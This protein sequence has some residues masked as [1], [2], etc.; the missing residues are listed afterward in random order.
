[1][2]PGHLDIPS[3][4]LALA[5]ALPLSTASPL[6]AQTTD[7][8]APPAAPLTIQIVPTAARGTDRPAL[9][10]HEPRDHFHVVLTNVSK[11]TIR[12]W[13]EWCS[14]G[15]YNLSFEA[16]N[17]GG[18]PKVISKRIPGWDDN[19][20]DWIALPPGEQLI[21]DVGLEPSLWKNSP[22]VGRAEQ[23]TLRLKAIFEIPDDEDSK[24][25]KVWTGRVTSPET[26]YVL[27]WTRSADRRALR[28]IK[29]P[30]S[31]TPPGT[32]ATR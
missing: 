28:R 7:A 16:R 19:F 8:Q 17:G 25:N 1:V 4:S 32:S 21:I 15:Y 14:W 12:L 9:Q 3:L 2:K 30:P 10:L 23:A 26:E 31:A 5:L 29:P 11:E 27:Y 6:A 24:A 13:K 18:K 22:L 20:P